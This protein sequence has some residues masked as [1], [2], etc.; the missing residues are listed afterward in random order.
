MA[1]NP[2]KRRVEYRLYPNKKQEA[3]L[4]TRLLAHQKLYNAILELRKDYFKKT[5][6]FL[7]RNDVSK[8]LTELRAS[9]PLYK[10]IN[11]QSLQ[12]TLKRNT[13]AFENFFRRI[14]NKETPGYPRFKS[15]DRFSS[16][17]YPS[18]GDGWTLIPGEPKGKRKMRHGKLRFEAEGFI[19]IRG[20]AKHEGT[21]KTLTIIYK[22]GCWY[23]SIVFETNPNRIAGQKRG[24]FDWGTE[25]FLTI[26]HEDDTFMSIPNPRNGQKSKEKLEKAQQSL[27]RKKKGSKNRGKAKKEVQKVYRKIKNQRKDFLHQTSNLLLKNYCFLA[28]EELNIQGLI[29]KNSEEGKSGLIRE[30]LDTSP[31]LFLGMIDYKA[32]EA[33]SE[34]TKIKTKKWKPSQTCSGCGRLVQKEL[35]DRRH[36]CTYCGLELSRDENS[37]RVCLNVALYGKAYAPICRGIGS[38]VKRSG[39]DRMFG[40]RDRQVEA[41]SI[42]SPSKGQRTAQAV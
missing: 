41:S 6:K 10:S 9:D 35:S 8:Q 37:A 20:A 38:S 26:A 31:S 30:I 29:Q 40:G 5:S 4:F 18:H 22:A 7:S 12:A 17:E 21:P 33:D 28:T 14:K 32:E 39:T 25:T 42:E 34:F 19:K 13:L 23:A 2:K 11:A 27:S 15:R 24:A 16:F 1:D 36:S 3:A